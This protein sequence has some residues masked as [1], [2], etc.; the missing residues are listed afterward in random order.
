VRLAE[1]WSEIREGLPQGWRSAWL[2]L[3]LDDSADADRAALL[4]GSAAPV[5]DGARFRLEAMRESSGV[6]VGAEVLRG[7]LRRLDA[8][9]V[10]GRLEE[11]SIEEAETARP[12]GGSLAGQWR[13]LVEALPPDWSHALASLE[14][15]SSDYR[16]RAAL[17]L[18]PANPSAGAD[19]RTLVFRTARRVGYGVSAEM[20]GRAL[21]RLDHEGIAGG[22]SIDHVVSESRPVATQGPVWRLGGRVA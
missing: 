2:T 10:T 9:G 11:T 19:P 8:D 3:E 21:E 22:V 7:V 4:L 13:K 6:G 15:G 14:L 20:A 18:S 1:Q 16:D 17:L 5:R 12:A